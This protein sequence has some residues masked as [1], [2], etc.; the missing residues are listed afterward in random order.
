MKMQCLVV[1]GVCLLM[2][3]VARAADW[4]EGYVVHKHSSSPDGQYGI[5]V[6][7]SEEKSDAEDSTNYL[8]NL[9]THQVLGKIADADYFEGRTTA[10]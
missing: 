5:V 2:S 8:A 9:N 7:G 10:A 3:I 4:P 6:P 1:A